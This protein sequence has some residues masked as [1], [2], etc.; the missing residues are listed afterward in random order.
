MKKVSQGGTELI[1]FKKQETGWEG[2]SLRSS[3]F[4]TRLCWKQGKSAHRLPGR[5]L[6]ALPP[7]LAVRRL[8]VK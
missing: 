2:G 7:R 1:V 4:Q 5:T 3:Y 6:L 8:Y